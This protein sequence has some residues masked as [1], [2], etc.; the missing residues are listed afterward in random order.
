MFPDARVTAYDYTA[1]NVQIL[2]AITNGDFGRGII[3]YEDTPTGCGAAQLQ[4]GLRWEEVV[5]RG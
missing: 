2:D 3:K 5:A 1:Q 4:I